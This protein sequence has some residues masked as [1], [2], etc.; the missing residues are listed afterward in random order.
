LGASVNSVSIVAE[1]ECF[2]FELIFEL[3]KLRLAQSLDSLWDD[4]LG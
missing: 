4:M 3:N 2:S 1:S